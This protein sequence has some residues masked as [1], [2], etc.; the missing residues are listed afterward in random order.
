MHFELDGRQRALAARFAELGR[1]VA[2]RA[3][4]MTIDA[5]LAAAERLEARFLAALA[6]RRARPEPMR[7]SA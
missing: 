3:E 4:I 7:L 1:G 5:D 6:H 2:T